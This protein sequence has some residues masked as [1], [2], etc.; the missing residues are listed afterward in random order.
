MS[1]MGSEWNHRVVESA[2]THMVDLAGRV[3]ADPNG[4][5]DGIPFS[6]SCYECSNEGPGTYY[7]AIRAG[8]TDIE[9]RPECYS[10]NFMGVCPEHSE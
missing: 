2:C 1:E 6:L 4:I 7:E 5:P 3:I 8:W 9:F 10:E